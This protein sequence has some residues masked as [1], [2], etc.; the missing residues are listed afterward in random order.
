VKGQ[1]NCTVGY[2][3]L[4]HYD[5]CHGRKYHCERQFIHGSTVHRATALLRSEVRF[6]EK[7]VN[8]LVTVPLTQNQFDALVIFTLNVGSSAFAKSTLLQ[9]VNAKR[10]A[11]APTAFRM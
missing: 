5:P 9:V 4:V 6:A 1:G 7:A 11:L 8:D 2:G 10:W 3:H